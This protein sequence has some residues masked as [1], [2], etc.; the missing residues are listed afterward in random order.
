MSRLPG[1]PT[2]PWCKGL[3]DGA[4]GANNDEERPSSG[5][6]SICVYCANFSVFIV[7]PR[8]DLYVLRKPNPAEAAQLALGEEYRRIKAQAEAIRATH[9]ESARDVL[10]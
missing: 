5:D 10:Q 6:V 3:L 9:P 4:M 2:C 1:K 8:I 7:D